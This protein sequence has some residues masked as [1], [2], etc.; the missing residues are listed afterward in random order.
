MSKPGVPTTTSCASRPMSSF[1]STS[2]CRC[3]TGACRN[4]ALVPTRRCEART[5]RESA[6]ASAHT[7]SMPTSTS[8]RRP[9]GT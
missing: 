1:I 8:A 4:R 9:R 2:S 6:K 3:E 7:T 5:G